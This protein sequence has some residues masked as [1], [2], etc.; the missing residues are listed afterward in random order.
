MVELAAVGAEAGG[1]GQG[2]A[3]KQRCCAAVSFQPVIAAIGVVPALHHGARDEAALSVGA[4]VVHAHV[5]AWVL[6]AG[7][8]LGI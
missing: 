4:A 7:Q 5:R 6:D 1:V 8:Q 3:V 2:D